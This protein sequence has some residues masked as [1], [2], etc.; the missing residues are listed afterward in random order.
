M[1][2]GPQDFTNSIDFLSRGTRVWAQGVYKGGSLAS[3]GPP[4][5]FA[6][7]WTQISCDDH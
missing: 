4:L 1:F 7:V 6:P 3:V 2:S 5:D